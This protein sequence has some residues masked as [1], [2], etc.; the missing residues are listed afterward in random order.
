[1][2]H[3]PIQLGL[4]CS[5]VGARAFPCKGSGNSFLL[6]IDWRCKIWSKPQG[7]QGRWFSDRNQFKNA[8]FPAQKNLLLA[9]ALPM[10][11][12]ESWL[13]RPFAPRLAVSHP[14]HLAINRMGTLRQTTTEICPFQ[15]TPARNDVK[16]QKKASSLQSMPE[17]IV[18]PWTLASVP[19]VPLVLTNS[20]RTS[21]AGGDAASVR[22]TVRF[23]T[24]VHL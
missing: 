15:D 9:G 13:W 17:F 8:G 6:K 19:C 23:D 21:S 11:R 10:Q 16:N 3:A 7:T 14:F 5:F 1:M 4:S 12:D 24:R 22:V 18:F 20:L 2:E